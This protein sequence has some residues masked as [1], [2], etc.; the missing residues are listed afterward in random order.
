MPIVKKTIL[1]FGATGQQGGSVATSLLEAGWQVR[2]FVRDPDSPKSIALRAA[3]AELVQGTFA[4]VSVIRAAM[5]GAHGV[6]S[7]QPSSGQG[8]ELGLSDMDEVRYGTSIADLAVECGIEHLVYSSTNALGGKPTGMGHFDSKAQIEG[9]IHKLPIKATIVRPAAFMEMLMMPGFGLDKGRFNFF[10]EKNQSMQ[11]LAVEDIGK[12]VAAVFADCARFS[13]KTFEIAS[14]SVTGGQLEAIFTEAAGHPIHYVR[15][16][17][18][19]L[20]ANPFLKKL[21]ELLNEGRLAGQ[22]DLTAMRA[23]NPEIQSFGTWLAGGGCQAFRTALG[24]SGE[25]AY[26]N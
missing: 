3:G 7:V 10:M 4:D 18:E 19:V 24:A 6:F 11:F 23:I 15:F 21:T 9:H 22:A 5:E 20:G 2:A 17:D 25:W 26:G 16:S 13:G 12:Y 8:A 1:V 14:D